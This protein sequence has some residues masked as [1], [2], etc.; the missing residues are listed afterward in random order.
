M[1]AGKKEKEAREIAY[2]VS[3]ISEPI[4]QTVLF[5]GAAAIN[6]AWGGYMK[7]QDKAM[8]LLQEQLFQNLQT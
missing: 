1:R 4:D 7:G 2:K 6:A 3:E 5:H 8:E